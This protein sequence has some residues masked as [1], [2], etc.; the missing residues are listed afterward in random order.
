MGN[1]LKQVCSNLRPFSLNLSDFPSITYLDL[2]LQVFDDIDGRAEVRFTV[3]LSTMRAATRHEYDCRQ[4]SS[5]IGEK[6]KHQILN[7]FSS[8]SFQQIISSTVRHSNGCVPRF[9]RISIYR[10]SIAILRRTH[11]ASYSP[12]AQY[13]RLIFKRPDTLLF[14]TLTLIPLFA[15]MLNLH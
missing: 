4:P 14:P 5:N 12:S 7:S 13:E 9:M 2:T 10:R 11:A 1:T 6:L 8:T 3:C 15:R